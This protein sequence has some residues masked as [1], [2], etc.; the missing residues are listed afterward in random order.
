MCI[1]LNSGNSFSTAPKSKS[2]DA[3]R[4]AAPVLSEPTSARAPAGSPANG[5]LS[6]GHD[7]QGESEESGNGA[8]WREREEAE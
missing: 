6:L 5:L 2:S 7:A 4:V 8:S 3:S 1:S